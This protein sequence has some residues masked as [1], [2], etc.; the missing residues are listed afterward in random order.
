MIRQH[1]W[2]A[3]L[4]SILILLPAFI[5]I[6]LP[7]NRIPFSASIIFQLFLLLTH[8]LALIF[9]FRDNRHNQQSGKILGMVFWLCPVISLFSS[10]VLYTAASGLK[11]D[12]SRIYLWM[13]L[14]W[15]L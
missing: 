10:G 5:G 2:K 9:T 11:P 4:S 12:M 13:K 14:P 15:V 1:K 6:F 8:W 7:E 3:I